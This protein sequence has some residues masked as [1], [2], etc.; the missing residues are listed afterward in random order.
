MS[1]LKNH[2]MVACS[3]NKDKDKGLTIEVDATV[4]IMM[5]TMGTKV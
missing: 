2:D 1:A 5:E 3:P 4:N